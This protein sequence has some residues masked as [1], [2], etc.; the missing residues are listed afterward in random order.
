MVSVS[1]TRS[2]TCEVGSSP[3]VKCTDATWSTPL[4]NILSACY[5]ENIAT[6][7]KPVIHVAAVN[8]ES[9]KFSRSI[10][11]V[12]DVDLRNGLK[13]QNNNTET[14]YSSYTAYPLIIYAP[15][16]LG[17]DVAQKSTGRYCLFAD[18]IIVC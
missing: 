3:S 18:Q 5:E 7:G 16:F 2:S 15:T 13:I 9:F 4:S 1:T 11:N 12:E 6:S 8:W 14:S 17:S 10:S